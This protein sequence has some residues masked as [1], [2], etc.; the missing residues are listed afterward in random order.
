MTQPAESVLNLRGLTVGYPERT[1]LEGVDL[2][3]Q[4][5]QFIVLLGP[6]GAGKTTLLRTLARL[7]APLG[8]TVLLGE[9]ML[10]H[11][12]QHELARLLSVVLTGQTVPG[13]MDAFQFASLGRYPH[14]GL[15]GSLKPRDVSV[16]E[17]SLA[18]VHASDLAHRRM[19]TL[20]DGERQK[21][22]IARALAQGPRIILLD[23]PTLHL[24]LKHRMEVMTI[25]QRLCREKGI[26]VVASMHDVDIAA[27]V[28]DRVALIR[29]GSI[30]AWG[31]PEEVLREETVRELYG[32][33]GAA[34][35]PW[36]GS[37][38]LSGCKGARGPVFVAGGVGKGAMLYRMLVRRGFTV[39]TGVLHTNDLDAYVAESLGL[40]RAVEKPMK[41]VTDEAYF[42]GLELL[43][44]AACVIDSGFP[45]EDLNRRNLDLIRAG[46]GMEKPVFSLRRS[47]EDVQAGRAS[48]LLHTAVVRCS[49][50]TEILEKLEA[51]TGQTCEAC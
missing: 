21:V 30:M 37:I 40:A 42:R 1:I 17:E 23:E 5:G 48:S 35:N 45:V 51:L 3:F 20:S 26:T 8:G 38:E 49:S 44:K 9:E 12:R 14:T 36:L 46:L 10:Q 31:G 33:Q 7:L 41:T 22:F 32:F 13:L 2:E 15:M 43:E 18:L 16:V 4:A 27:K 24:D 50:E 34:F 47:G 29:E 39:S 25:M 6:N 11:I 28:A 19:Q